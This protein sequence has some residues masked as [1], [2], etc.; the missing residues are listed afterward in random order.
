MSASFDEVLAQKKAQLEKLVEAYGGIMVGHPTQSD[1]EALA[2]FEALR[3]VGEQLSAQEN[4]Q[5]NALAA[6]FKGSFC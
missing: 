3:E 4:K 2:R 1:V 6:K 5:A